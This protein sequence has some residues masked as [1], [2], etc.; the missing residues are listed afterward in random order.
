MS[1]SQARSCASGHSGAG[2]AASLSLSARR[3]LDAGAAC[4]LKRNSGD[5]RVHHRKPLSI[6]R[7]TGGIGKSDHGTDV[8]TD[9][10]TTPPL[11]ATGDSTYS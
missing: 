5:Q 11:A 10:P 7:I 1:T 6:V 2:G 3:N 8:V 4:A 9:G